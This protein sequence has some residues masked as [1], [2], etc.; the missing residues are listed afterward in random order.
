MPPAN[1]TRTATTGTAKAGAAKKSA[2]A[3]KAHRS[4]AKRSTA[5]HTSTRGA[6]GTRPKAKTPRSPRKPAQLSPRA[7]HAA[8]GAYLKTLEVDR[9]TRRR[10]P[11]RIAQLLDDVTARIPGADVVERLELVQRRIDL[12]NEAAALDSEPDV[13][14]LETS[15]VAAAG[16]FGDR[17]GISYAAWR[18]VGVPAALLR[19][20]GITRATHA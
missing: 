13:D 18:E 10:S 15:F 20:A 17:K 1:K 16:P 12:E 7:Q 4:P 14:E 6:A 19:R 2:T 5:T 8:V 3:A 9:R 11:E